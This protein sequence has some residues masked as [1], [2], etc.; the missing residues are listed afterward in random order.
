M[1][2]VA[3]IATLQNKLR[4]LM[5]AV[6]QFEGESADAEIAQKIRE[7]TIESLTRKIALFAEVEADRLP[8]SLARHYGNVDQDIE[9]RKTPEEKAACE[10]YRR[11]HAQ[12]YAGAREYLIQRLEA[13]RPT[14]THR[15]GTD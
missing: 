8:G 14:S 12:E 13:M 9:D 3:G 6:E 7:W 4:K 10:R 15:R 1:A 11:L 2:R 5:E